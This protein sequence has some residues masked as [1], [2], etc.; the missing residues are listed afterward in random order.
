M[1]KLCTLVLAGMLINQMIP[2][3]TA[4]APENKITF[5][6]ER[7]TVDGNDYEII[8]SYYPNG[9]IKSTSIRNVSDSEQATLSFSSKN[10]NPGICEYFDQI[11]RDNSQQFGVSNR[12]RQTTYDDYAYYT[13]K[14]EFSDFDRNDEWKV[15]VETYGTFYR[16][17]DSQYIIKV[18][19]MYACGKYLGSGN[20][21]KITVTS[22]YEGK[23]IL[24]ILIDLLNMDSISAIALFVSDDEVTIQDEGE[25]AWMLSLYRSPVIFGANLPGQFHVTVADETIVQLRANGHLKSHHLPAPVQEQYYSTVLG[26]NWDDL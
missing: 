17:I 22:H 11:C 14:K 12:N 19:D 16:G 18:D 8:D 5:N 20:A 9:N 3:V 26:D 24:G 10:K 21:E 23:G 2:S 1:K 7:V 25:D 13:G 15:Q 4:M 6:K